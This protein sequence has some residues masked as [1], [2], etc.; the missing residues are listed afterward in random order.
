MEY[1]RKGFPE[2]FRIRPPEEDLFYTFF[3]KCEE[4]EEGSRWL[5]AAQ[6]MYL[7][8][9]RTHLVMASGGNVRLGILLRKEGFPVL[10][11][12]N[13]CLYQVMRISDEQADRE[14]TE[15]PVS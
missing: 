5:T 8:C 4:G 10:K 15:Q 9:L 6:I 7:L 12:K 3:R 13:K 11:R 2:V 14:K 1:R